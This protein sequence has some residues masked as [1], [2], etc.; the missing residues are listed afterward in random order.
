MATRDGHVVAS[1]PDLICVLDLETGEPITTEQMRYG[2]RV[3][4]VMLPSYEKWRTPEGPRDRRSEVLRVRTRVRRA[5]PLEKALKNLGIRLERSNLGVCV[6]LLIRSTSTAMKDWRACCAHCQ[7]S[8]AHLALGWA[9]LLDLTGE[10]SVVV[11]GLLVIGLLV[12]VTRG[13]GRRDV[14][15]LGAIAWLLVT[16]LSPTASASCSPWGPLMG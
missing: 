4:V 16:G 11:R 6:R 15:A 5:Q 12:V 10:L 3:S 9:G 7:Q 1:V 2:F 14:L 13:L 8:C